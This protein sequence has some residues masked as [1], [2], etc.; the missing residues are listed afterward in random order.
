MKARIRSW[1]VLLALAF[2]AAA[3]ADQPTLKVGDPAPKLQNG[4]WVQG[5]PVKEFDR[6]KAYIVEFWATWCGPC[7]ASIPHLNEH[8]VKF[9]DK[10]LVVIGQDCWEQD[11][12]LVVPFVKTMG[13]NMTY[14]VALD[15]KK[16]DTKGV[17]AKTW[18]EAAGQNGIPTA[19]LIG[20]DGRVAWI[21]HPMTLEDSVIEDVLAG[22]YNVEKAAADYAERTKN[23]ARMNALWRDLNAARQKK[24]WDE[25]LAKLDDYE[26]LLPEGQR[27][28]MEVQR[29]SILISKKDYE[30]AYK[31]A[32]QLSDAHPDD[33]Y[34]QN[35]LAWQ[36]VSDPG[37]EKPDLALADKIAT[38]AVEASKSKDA[39]NLDTL[40]CVLFMEGKQDRAVSLEEQAASLA[41]DNNKQSFQKTL[42]S[43]KNGTD[44]P[45]V[46]NRQAA[47]FRNNGKPAE[48]EAA[49]REELAVEQKLWETNSARWEGTVR[50]LVAVLESEKK[51]D[52][53]EKLY[54]AILTPDFL[55]QKESANL[56][57]NR[58]NFFATHGRWKEAAVDFTQV[59]ALTPDNHYDYAVLAPLL[60]QCNDL[61]AYQR[62]CAK[63]LGRFGDTSDP[64]IAERMAKACLFTTN[65]GTDLATACKMADFAVTKAKNFLWYQL[66]EGMAEY[67]QGHFAAAEEH[68]KLALGGPI[69]YLNAGA[70]LVLAMAQ[71]Q[72]KKTDEARASLDKGADLIDTKMPKIDKGELGDDSWNDWITDRVLLREARELIGSPVVVTDE[73]SRGPAK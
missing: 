50:Q 43:Y 23:E 14:R 72:L 53:V 18:M 56:L 3:F 19:F 45:D 10:N 22:K 40:A 9:K 32:G 70:D 48:A 47:Y 59:I 49:L 54:A 30:A 29:F 31:L 21:G 37:I 55:S 64:V 60:V 58:G 25:A 52:E 24:N 38:R 2:G 73:A 71:Y 15:D 46:L 51:A 6:D 17:M 5:D 35:E 13:S 57:R 27:S 4:Q 67:R 42:E 41:P 68:S 39:N 12:N 44:K 16:T 36:I 65:S 8:Y 7:R 61:E 26:K 66:A 20:K 62:L 63:I 34:S 33:A 28:G 1:M 11:D 69:P